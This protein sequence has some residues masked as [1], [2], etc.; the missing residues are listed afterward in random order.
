MWRYEIFYQNLSHRT[1]SF[2]DSFHGTSPRIDDAL[3]IR[4]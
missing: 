4:Y 1:L 3:P 2:T